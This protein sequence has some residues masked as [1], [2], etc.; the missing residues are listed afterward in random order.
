[1]SDQKTNSPAVPAAYT[2]SGAL[3]YVS[4]STSVDD[5]ED[6]ISA[7]KKRIIA[8][9][10]EIIEPGD[11]VTLS[12]DAHMVFDKY[13]GKEHRVM[14]VDRNG[15]YALNLSGIESLF[16]R[17]KILLIRKRGE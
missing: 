5:L 13:K 3:G 1:M 11:I 14:T 12:D 15:R 17:D 6:L 8:M 7:A 9:T 16:S 10:E 4:S 2:L